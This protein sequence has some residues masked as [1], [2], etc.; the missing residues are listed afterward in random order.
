MTQTDPPGQAEAFRRWGDIAVKTASG[1]VLVAVALTFRESADNYY[2]LADVHR[3]NAATAVAH[4]LADGRASLDGYP[5]MP[6]DVL[7]FAGSA[8][9]LPVFPPVPTER[10]EAA[11]AANTAMASYATTQ[12]VEARTDGRLL[13]TGAGAVSILGGRLLFPLTS[14]IAELIVR[15]GWRDII[16]MRRQWRA[17]RRTIASG[18]ARPA[19][20][21]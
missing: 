11:V 18:K 3:Q 16:A 21:R 19:Q 5:A 2:A 15:H 7:E 1:A 6:P 14:V 8:D 13:L 10:A 4:A 17:R 12:G 9:S 20:G